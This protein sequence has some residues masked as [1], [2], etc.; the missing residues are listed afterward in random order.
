MARRNRYLGVWLD[1]LRVARLERAGD[2]IRC[3]YTEEGLALGP[4]NSPLLSCS[5]P[6]DPRPLDALPFCAGLLPEG[7][8]LQTLA[9]QAGLPA[10][11]AFG[12]LARYG[13]D[14]AGALVIVPGDEEPDPGQF[15]AEPYDAETLAG[16]VADLDD[17]PL[18]AHDD[19]ELSLAGIQD[20]L[21]LVRLA[22]GSWG[23]P[24]GGRPSTHIL[25]RDDL[26]FPGLIEA[27]AHC[28]IL[29]RAAGLTATDVELTELASHPCLIVSRYD[30]EV[31]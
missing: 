18:G 5:L 28:L 4:L 10:G 30:R 27:E 9:E 1:G 22:D 16:A 19:S 23:R 21:L 29:A 7:Q 2:G 13:R 6:L 11:D 3:R 12:L 17:F 14:V 20:K 24:T 15:G 31:D 8:A 25:K 26:R